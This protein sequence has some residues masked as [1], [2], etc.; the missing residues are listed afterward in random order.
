MYR[1]V[2][3]ALAVVA[4]VATVATTATA[5]EALEPGS[6]ALPALSGAEAG[7]TTAGATP[8]VQWVAEVRPQPSLRLF[9][10]WLAAFNSGDPSRY[11]RFLA[12]NFPSRAPMF[13]PDM[14]FRDGT[15][16]FVLRKLG[17]VSAT[18][19]SG[20]VQERDSD[21][22]G[23]FVL[24]VS[25]SRPRKILTL[26]LVAIPRPAAFP[27]PRLTEGEA[28]AGVEALLRK[29]TAADQFSGAALVAK[30]GEVRFG[31]AYGLADRERGIA[32][33]IET[34]FR[35]GSMN[36]MFTAVA[37]LQLVE[38][39]KL[40]LDDTVGKHLPG[41]PN[42]D[43]ASK[44]TVRH[45][46]T[47]TG[48]TGDIFG[49]EFDRD[50]LTLR[51]HGDYVKLYGSR[52]PGF[53]P[54]SRFEY[55]NYGFVLL[56][57]LIE[58]VSG[59]SYYDYVRENVFRP[60]GMTSTDSLP[61]SEDVPKPFDR[62]HALWRPIVAAQH[63]LA[64]LEGYRRRWR[65]LDGRRLRALRRRAHE[66]RASQPRLHGAAARRESRP[67]VRGQIRVRILRQS[68]RKWKR[69]GR[70]RGRFPGHERGPEDLPAIRVRGRGAGE[71]GSPGG[72][73]DLGLPRPAAS[74]G[75]AGK[76]CEMKFMK[77]T[78]IVPL[79]IGL[80]LLA[81][82]TVS[83]AARRRTGGARAAPGRGD[84]GCR[85]C[86]SRSLPR[87]HPTPVRQ[88]PPVRVIGDVA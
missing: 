12:R 14:G 49:P 53:E 52:P 26:E 28:I 59:E 77:G 7:E 4:A 40:A 3:A 31:R 78:G 65:L 46:L 57:A 71:R 30:D 62:L 70:A 61:E 74:D 24:T 54:G 35:I 80:T 29:R 33:T 23:R 13:L 47:H 27:I 38:E 79:V 58:A 6:L 16:G 22:F 87:I 9:R 32:N 45:L 34:R 18:R 51:E 15:G 36:K 69:L 5:G 82:P 20:W 43:V 76:S 56:G 63:R 66:S 88:R 1:I 42:A 17:R 2:I 68:R 25:A 50:R 41:Y 83:G 60:A 21:Q 48:G 73:A 55:S 86:G 75:V 19:V 11:W 10:A 64:S 67:R 85:R 8:T 81:V 84:A 37:T 44:V 72:T 39:G